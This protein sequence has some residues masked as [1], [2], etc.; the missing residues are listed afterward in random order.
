MSRHH[1]W[2][3]KKYSVP[4]QGF[5]DFMCYSKCGWNLQPTQETQQVDSVYQRHTRISF[6]KFI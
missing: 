5:D 4:L 1:K 6:V 2:V 3:R